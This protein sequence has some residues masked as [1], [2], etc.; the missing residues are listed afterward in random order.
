MRNLTYSELL[1]TN[2]SEAEWI[3][4]TDKQYINNN[5]ENIAIEVRP[6]DTKEYLERI[7]LERSNLPE[8]VDRSSREQTTIGNAIKALEKC[9]DYGTIIKKLKT[10]TKYSG[11]KD[12]PYRTVAEILKNLSFYEEYHYQEETIMTD[13]ILSKLIV[14]QTIESLENH[15]IIHPKLKLLMNLIG[16]LDSIDGEVENSD[17]GNFNLSYT[18]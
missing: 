1:E 11:D 2:F 3:N 15:S 17:S 7:I 13:D 4:I 8:F 9:S 18:T 6:E 5:G 14:T 10:L 12:F 16:K